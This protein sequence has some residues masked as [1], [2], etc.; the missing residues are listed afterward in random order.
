MRI[1]LGTTRIVLLIGDKAVK[2]GRLRPLRL[3]ARML[4]L[5]F[6]WQRRQHFL[7]KYGPKFAQA[8]LNDLCAGLYANRN[9]YAYYKVYRDSRVMPTTE[10][11]CGG[12]IIIQPRGTPISVNELSEKP[13][14]KQRIGM[15]SC[16]VDTAAQFCRHPD[17]RIVLVDYG[18]RAT[19][20][21][22]FG[23]LRI[24]V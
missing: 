5:P 6:S 2:I 24:S 9:E 23:T 22:L 13:S 3:L 16:E 19:T 20:E 18:R 21:V 11:L 17:G 4:L 15:E 12:W 7:A 14:L 8:M 10:Q 1:K